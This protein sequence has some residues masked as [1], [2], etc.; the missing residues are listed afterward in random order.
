ML[1]QPSTGY[2]LLRKQRIEREKRLSGLTMEKYFREME[3]IRN[4]KS[5]QPE[6][7]KYLLTRYN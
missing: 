3:D 6:F 7:K 2:Q 4:G 5:I 1:G